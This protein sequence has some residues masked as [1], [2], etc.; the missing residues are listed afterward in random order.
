MTRPARLRSLAGVVLAGGLIVGCNQ[1]VTSTQTW[2]IL[3][4]TNE[5]MLDGTQYDYSPDV[6]IGLPIAVNGPQL[7]KYP[8]LTIAVISEGGVSVFSPED[9]EAASSDEEA[10]EAEPVSLASPCQ[11]RLACEFEVD[12]P[13]GYFMLVV[14]DVDL[15]TRHDYVDGWIFTDRQRGRVSQAR[16]EDVEARARA[17]MESQVE[18]VPP[19]QFPV[20]R[21]RDCRKAACEANGLTGTASVSV[22][23][24]VAAAAAATIAEAPAEDLPETDEAMAP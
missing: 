9:A 6:I 14:L 4:Q 7:S 21:R 8:D 20:V 15:A 2:S 1:P 17:W 24:L 12:V 19:L 3:V 23:P 18:N 10:D 16:V 13:P 5:L 11:N 22:A